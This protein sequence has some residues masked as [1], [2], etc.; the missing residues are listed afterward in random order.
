MAVGVPTDVL[1]TPWFTRMTPVRWWELPVLVATALLTGAWIAVGRSGSRRRK[2]SVF[3]SNALSILAVGCPVCN[4]I[5]V[6]LLGVSG[7]LAIWAPLQPVLA[8]GSLMLLAS[9]VLVR[10]VQRRS[11]KREMRS[12]MV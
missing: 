12:L 8:V 2:A 9:A 6:W 3:G 7:S 4:K 5:V 1:N 11:E 10:L